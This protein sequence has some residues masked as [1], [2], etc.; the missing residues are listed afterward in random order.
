MLQDTDKTYADYA[1]WHKH[2]ANCRKY[3]GTAGAHIL[4]TQ[5]SNVEVSD[6]KEYLKTHFDSNT[7]T[8]GTV[9]RSF[10]TNCGSSLG[11][12]GIPGADWAFVFLG[13]FPRIPVPAEELFTA[14][15]HEWVKPIEGATQYEFLW[16]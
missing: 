7:R 4:R 1:P 12:V 3:T 14:H 8:G 16:T 9:P 15:R 11:A 10:C 13:L 5:A 6:P 2:C